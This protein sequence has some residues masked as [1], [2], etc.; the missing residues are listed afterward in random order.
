MYTFMLDTNIVIYVIKERPLSVLKKFNQ[1]SGRV[2]VSMITVAELYSGAENSKFVAKNI[3]QVEEFLSRIAVL[4]YDIEAAREY[5][6]I[7]ASLARQG[8]MISE[9]DMHIAGHA[10]SLGLVV[11]TNNVGEFERI[12]DLKI[13]N[14]SKA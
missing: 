11:I 1:Y 14:W 10:R 5:G 9:N 7:Y 8:G 3:R 6:K 13:E 12:E 2:C 4:D